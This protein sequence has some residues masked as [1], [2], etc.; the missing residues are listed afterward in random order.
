MRYFSREADLKG[1]DKTA[2]GKKKI[3]EQFFYESCSQHDFCERHN[4]VRY[5]LNEYIKKH[6]A[7]THHGLDLFGTKRGRPSA[8]DS[9]SLSLIRET[10]LEAYSEQKTLSKEQV[11]QLIL[12]EM[13]ATSARRGKANINP[14]P[15]PKTVSSILKTIKAH[16]VKAQEKT[17]A[18]ITAE[19]DPRNAFTMF[20]MAKAYCEQTPP[21]LIFNWDATQFVVDSA[22]DTLHVYIKKE[23]FDL[24][25]TYEG[26]GE[27]SF[28]IKLF[29][30]HNAAGYTAPPVLVIAD[31][32]I[33]EEDFIYRRVEGLSH[34]M[35]SDAYGYVVFSKTRCGNP[36]F[37]KWYFEDVVVPFVQKWKGK[38]VKNRG[39]PS[40]RDVF[41][42]GTCDGEP[43]QIEVFQTPEVLDILSTNK[44]YLGK[45]PASCSAICQSSDV[46][47]FFKAC[48]K[49]LKSITER[50]L[51]H[52]LLEDAL[53]DAFKGDHISL[54]TEVRKKAIRGVK[55]IVATLR[56]CN[57]DKVIKMGYEETGQW[58]LDFRRAMSKC[59]TSL[60]EEELRILEGKVPAVVD[61]FRRHGRVTEEEMDRLGV[62]SIELLG[63][64]RKLPKDS[65]V[66]HQ[67]RAVIMNSECVV[68]QYQ[69]RMVQKAIAE[70]AKRARAENNGANVTR[71]GRK[72]KA[73]DSGREDNAPPA[74]RD[75]APASAPV[76]VAI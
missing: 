27:L 6:H 73:A 44:I 50:D 75:N 32:N 65:R 13:V 9:V 34:L 74:S 51:N 19:S 52:A 47:P 37:F 7:L 48:K 14:D 55:M 38:I 29:H 17:N 69:A 60:T 2:E 71:R 31:P 40:D 15:H 46:S 4:V 45:T 43:K 61:L 54:S 1:V 56:G 10:I 76:N 36:K 42:F 68:A 49:R 16:T 24:P 53:E 8:V 5:N 21:H 26:S 12:T 67:Q 64:R 28:A 35:H 41:A 25:P 3:V 20:A 58:P 66:L 39:N 22:Q 62:L 63:D 33:K 30:L 23:N 59:T 57:S 11:R 70:A 72:R 18:R